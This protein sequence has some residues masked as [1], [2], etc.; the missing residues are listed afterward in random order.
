MC[1]RVEEFIGMLKF[2]AFISRKDLSWDYFEIFTIK[3]HPIFV[4]NKK[5]EILAKI[6]IAN[7]KFKENPTNLA[8]LPCPGI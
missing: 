7:Q 3:K 1:V 4:Y 5:W 6:R 8:Y 2:T